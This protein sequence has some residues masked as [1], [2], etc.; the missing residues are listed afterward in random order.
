ME[1]KANLHSPSMQQCVITEVYGE[2]AVGNWDALAPK[3]PPNSVCDSCHAPTEYTGMATGMSPSPR[4]TPGPA[5]QLSETLG[6][7]P[8]ANK[9]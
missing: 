6:L 9:M 8:H 2:E 1:S 4:A 7:S 3:W 5:K